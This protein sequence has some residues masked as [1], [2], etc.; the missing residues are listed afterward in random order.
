M[1]QI[2]GRPYWTATFDESGALTGTPAAELVGEIA[3]SGVVDLFVFSHGWNTQ[4]ADAHTL[5]AR[6]FPLIK[7]K[8]DGEPSV[9]SIG[10]VGVVWPSI[11]F[12]D[13]PG[14]AEAAHG[15][16]AQS[17]DGSVAAPVNVTTTK[18][19]AEITST[20][21]SA[22]SAGE[23]DVLAQ[24]GR[25]ID[26]GLRQAGDGTPDAVQRRNVEEFHALL[27]QLT[28]AFDGAA[29]DAG[30]LALTSSEQPV[31]DYQKLATAMST[32]TDAGD[33]QGIGS[34]FGKVWNGAKDALRVATFWKMKA[35]AGQ[36]GRSGLGPLLEQLHIAAP[37]VRVHLIG[38]SFGARLVA[39]A[40][41]GVSGAAASPIASLTLVQ[42]AFSHWAFA[43]HNPWDV[44]GSLFGTA[45]RVHGPLVA[46]FS[47][48]DWAVGRWYPKASFL[49]GDDN[50]AAE[51]AGRWG[52]MGSDGFQSSGPTVE[53]TLTAGQPSYPM[54]VGTFHP[55]DANAIIADTSQS[56]FAGA[57]SDIVRDEVGW[58]IVQAARPIH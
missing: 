15:I 47:A 39:N 49:A 38:H 37:T 10:F 14:T 36:V 48:A 50:Q 56:A 12:P 4:I 30:E 5:Y 41:A 6:M 27:R 9:S 7:A 16:G 25:L 29:E 57:H 2:E 54:A 52:G 1:D 53:L 55:V 51:H 11:A 23:Q 34:F 20:M 8:A 42:G 17:A 33:A 3:D 46:T 28:G 19:G 44:Q 24:M 40:L 32:G 35:R 21:A 45:D 22:F 58:L 18:S 43:Q 31:E 26:D 13:D